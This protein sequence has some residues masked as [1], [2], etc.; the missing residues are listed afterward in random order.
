M[1]LDFILEIDKETFIYL[2]SLGSSTFDKFWLLIS[3][4][5]SSIP[6]YIFLIYFLKKNLNLKH[7]ISS[8]IFIGLLI[9]FT[10]QI[11]G[12][13]KDYYERLRPC[14]DQLIISKIR[15]VKESCGGLYSFFSSHA[16]NSF[17]LASFFYFLMSKKNK[18]IKLIFV[19]ALTVSY[20]RIYIG[21]HFPLDII[22]GTFFGLFSGYL[23]SRVLNK[24]YNVVS[25]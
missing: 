10:D 24:K 7:F 25:I 9:L 1:N 13:F 15:I 3:D 17:A 23:F 20:S 21:V 4:K 5:K 22:C 16:S 2:N 12:F 8:I 11:S 14:H 19:W 6:L 18:Y